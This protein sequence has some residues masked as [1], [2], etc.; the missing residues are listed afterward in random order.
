MMRRYI[1]PAGNHLRLAN[2]LAHFGEN[3][4]AITE[5]RVFVGNR[6]IVDPNAELCVGDEIAVAGDEPAPGGVALLGRYRGL[7][8]FSK[9]P[10]LPAIPGHRGNAS[11]LHEAARALEV[12]PEALHVMTRLDTNVSGVVLVAHGSE[13]MEWASGLQKEHAIVRRY[14]GLCARTPVP[15]AGTWNRPV[16]ARRGRGTRTRHAEKPAR[17]NYETIRAADVTAGKAALVVFEP[18]TGRTHQ[19]RIHSAAAE[20]P[21]LGDAA[22][23]GPRR[24]VLLDGTVLD[25]SRVALH[26]GRVH[27]VVR[28]EIVLSAEAP[29]PADLVDVWTRLGGSRTDFDV[30][31]ALPSLDARKPACEGK[32]DA[33]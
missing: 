10:G 4:A 7:F 15:P 2:S 33:V 30:A 32:L 20:A 11:V 25:V 5:G 26:A 3:P 6:R 8:A 27:V 21:L 12:A 22:Y 19:I 31:F 13:T 29:H 23:G 24:V 17:T 16:A 14:V 28:G 9:P 18:I 1:V